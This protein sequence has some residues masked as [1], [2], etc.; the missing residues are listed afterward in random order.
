M[1]AQILPIV[2]GPSAYRRLKEEARAQER[3]PLQQARWILKQHLDEHEGER[4]ATLTAD[5]REP[6]ALAR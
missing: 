2:L 4:S 3:D 5:S 1:R 6:E